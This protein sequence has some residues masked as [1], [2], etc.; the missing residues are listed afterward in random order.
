MRAEVDQGSRMKALRIDRGGEFTS[1]MFSVFCTE[2]GIKHYTTTPHTPQQNGVAERRNQTVVEMARCMMKSM[3]VP[4]EFLAEAVATAVYVLNRSPTRSLKN[5]TSIEMWHGK[6]P[7]VDHLRTFGCTAHVKLMGPGLTK[8]ADRSKKM[9]LLGYEAGTK[10][11][12]L[13]DPEINKITVSRD[14]IFEENVP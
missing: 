5:K 13:F 3:S 12:K 7:R 10:G 1:N 2:T 9:V 11:Y 14:V 6:K 4:A 8:L